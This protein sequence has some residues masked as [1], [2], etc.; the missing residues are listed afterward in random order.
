[1][2]QYKKVG[3][4]EATDT[5]YKTWEIKECPQCGRLVRE[6]YVCEVVERK[7]VDYLLNNET[8]TSKTQEETG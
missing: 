4:G 8:D 3:G 6:T 5:K 7:D 2:H 1:M